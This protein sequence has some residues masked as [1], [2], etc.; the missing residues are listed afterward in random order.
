MVRWRGYPCLGRSGG[1]VHAG[2][3]WQQFLYWTAIVP[4]SLA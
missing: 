1:S 3:P 4:T 2:S